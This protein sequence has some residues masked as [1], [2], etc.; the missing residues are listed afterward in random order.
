M[1]MKTFFTFFSF[2]FL[3]VL[4]SVIIAGYISHE[5]AKVREAYTRDKEEQIKMVTASLADSQNKIALLEEKFKA[6]E[7]T[8]AKPTTTAPVTTTKPVTTTPKP[9]PTP[10]VPSGTKLTSAVVAGHGSAADCW[11]IVSGKVYSVSSYLAMHPGGKSTIVTNCGKD[12]TTVF[13]NRG[14]TGEHSS[15]AWT[16]LGQFLVGAMGATVKL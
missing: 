9:T 3:G 8:S 14:G 11:I 5:N 16:M 13:K 6:L 12:A 1:S 4:A 15:S 10:T 7:V 2:L